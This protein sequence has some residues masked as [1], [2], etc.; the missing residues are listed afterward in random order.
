MTTWPCFLVPVLWPLP[1]LGLV[2]PQPPLGP[3]SQD[4]GP[5]RVSPADAQRNC[6]AQR[7]G[8][9]RTPGLPGPVASFQWTL[10]IFITSAYRSDL[11]YCDRLPLHI[12]TQRA[13]GRAQA[14]SEAR[15]PAASAHVWTCGDDCQQ[16]LRP[17]ARGP[18]V[19]AEAWER[20]RGLVP[21]GGR[22]VRVVEEG[23]D[24]C[25]TPG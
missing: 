14:S 23:Q 6:P 16:G 11:P 3:A 2:D 4:D 5:S 17:R 15:P 9:V 22:G 20:L 25:K 8:F 1:R 12:P 7:Q 19:S 13:G 21:G 10:G 18:G 24:T